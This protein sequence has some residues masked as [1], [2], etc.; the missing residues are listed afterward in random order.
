MSDQTLKLGATINFYYRG[1][2][3]TGEIIYVP[4][5]PQATMAIDEKGRIV[6]LLLPAP[7]VVITQYGEHLEIYR[8][9][10]S[11]QL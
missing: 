8:S 2:Q 6:S 3:L 7:I 11:Q 10:I 5:D 1:Q 9:Q 4:A